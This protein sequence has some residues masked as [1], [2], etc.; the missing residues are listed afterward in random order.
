MASLF[1]KLMIG[2]R[3]AFMNRRP[4]SR[5]QVPNLVV[6]VHP[7]TGDL[8][9]VAVVVDFQMGFEELEVG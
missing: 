4:L 5:D 9:V 6:M 8:A 3:Q 7:E 1:G 2:F